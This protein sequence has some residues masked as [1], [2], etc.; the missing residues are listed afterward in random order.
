[1]QWSMMEESAYS[2]EFLE[3]LNNYNESMDNA[4]DLVT[5]KKTLDDIYL[6]LDSGEYS[7]FYL[8]FDPSTND[9]RDEATL[10]LLIEHFSLVE[11]YEK[12]NELLKLKNKCLNEQID[13]DPLL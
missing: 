12:C 5:K 2:M 3:D 4:Y 10:D 11:A 8:P 6:E 1:M 13:S 7:K 9:G